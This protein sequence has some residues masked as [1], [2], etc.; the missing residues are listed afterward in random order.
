MNKYSIGTEILHLAL[1]RKKFF[2][3]YSFIGYW[4]I[5]EI[6]KEAKIDDHKKYIEVINKNR[7][8]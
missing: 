5:M 8:K 1:E 6:N 7:L 2:R 3:I 4:I